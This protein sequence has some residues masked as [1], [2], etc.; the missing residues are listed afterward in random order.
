MP[1]T[2]KRY[3]KQGAGQRSVEREQNAFTDQAKNFKPTG[4]FQMTIQSVEN[5]Q[6]AEPKEKSVHAGQT[7]ANVVPS[8]LA[9][10]VTALT[11]VGNWLT[12]TTEYPSA[13]SHKFM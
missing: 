10:M 3:L 2:P 6:P 7:A 11:M 9:T 8:Q 1:D 13:F 5:K 12:L 4:M